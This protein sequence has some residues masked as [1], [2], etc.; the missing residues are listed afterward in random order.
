MPAAWPGR[1]GSL[2]EP[3]RACES[4]VSRVL[5]G[6]GTPATRRPSCRAAHG[7][8]SVC[9][10]GTEKRPEPEE[11]AWAGRLGLGGGGAWARPGPPG[12]PVYIGNH[13]HSVSAQRGFGVQRAVG[14]WKKCVSYKIPAE[15]WAR[16]TF[17]GQS[18]P[19]LLASLK[20]WKVLCLWEAAP[21][22]PAVRG[23]QRAEPSRLVLH[24]QPGVSGPEGDV[25]RRSCSGLPTLSRWP[26]QATPLVLPHPR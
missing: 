11:G 4:S 21:P 17:G 20:R 3:S 24:T 10:A 25:L 22:V 2:V 19:C 6:G 26:H 18:E 8:C 1:C 13:R 23:R 7:V 5:P 12:A 16:P 14:K 15:C 9:V